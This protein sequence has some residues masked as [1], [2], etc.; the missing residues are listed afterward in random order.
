MKYF[1]SV[2]LF[3]AACASSQNPEPANPGNG[4][5]RVVCTEETPTGDLIPRKVCRTVEMRD[6]QKDAADDFVSRP[7]SSP[8]KNK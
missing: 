2:L 1:L 4:K 7:T 8:T 5:E 6:R 3:S